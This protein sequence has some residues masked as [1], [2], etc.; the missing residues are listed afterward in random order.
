MNESN[1]I[2]N[3]LRGESNR[4]DNHLRGKSNVYYFFNE[5][6]NIYF[7]EYFYSFSIF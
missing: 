1:H 5:T 6:K 4:I 7:T 3:H 2:D